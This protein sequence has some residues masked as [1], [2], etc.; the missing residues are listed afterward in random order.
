[1]VVETE[2]TQKTKTYYTDVS[3][4]AVLQACVLLP[5]LIALALIVDAVLRLR[6]CVQGGADKLAISNFQIFWHIG[7][8][9]VYLITT[10]IL[11]SILVM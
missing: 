7:S 11:I 3:L 1:M 8:F 2:N 4:N 6:R 10:L 9:A 5:S